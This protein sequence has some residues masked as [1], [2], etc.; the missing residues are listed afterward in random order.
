MGLENM[1][2]LSDEDFTQNLNCAKDILIP[3]L[4]KD[5]I[6]DS[7]KYDEESLCANYV[8]VVKRKG[9]FGKMYDKIINNNS[10]DTYIVVLRTNIDVKNK[11]IN[12]D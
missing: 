1:R 9:L 4:I 6:I 5:G 2:V 7:E 10:S 12:N 11:D 3:A 8:I